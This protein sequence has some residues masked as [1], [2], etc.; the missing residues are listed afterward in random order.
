MNLVLA[1]EELFQGIHCD[2]WMDSKKNPYMTLEQMSKA[3]EYKSKKGIEQL[4]ERNPYLKQKEFSVLKKVPLKLGGTQEM[5]LFTRDG[6]IEIGFLSPKPN[7]REFRAWARKVLNA[8]IDGQLVWKEQR[9]ISKIQHKELKVIIAQ[10]YPQ[11]KVKIK[12]IN[13]SQLLCEL[14]TG[15][16]SVGGYKKSIGV[17]DKRPLAELLDEKQL[18]EYNGYLNRIAVFLESDFSYKEISA[19]LKKKTI[20]ITI[21][22]KEL[23]GTK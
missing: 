5:R 10:Y 2:L 18:K 4:V 6:I 17:S 3:L 21:Q 8:F 12:C 19:I 11:E 20:C 9:E 14:I 16:K 15:Y 22:K 1:Q 13:F 23:E 7:A